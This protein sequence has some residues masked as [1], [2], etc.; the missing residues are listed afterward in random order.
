MALARWR[1]TSDNKVIAPVKGRA[2]NLALAIHRSQVYPRR[3]KPS[4][5]AARLSRD[6]REMVQQHP[7]S[8]SRARASASRGP[9]RM[10]RS[11][12]YAT[13]LERKVPERKTVPRYDLRA[14]AFS[15]TSWNGR[16]RSRNRTAIPWQTLIADSRLAARIGSFLHESRMCPRRNNYIR[17][18]TG[19]RGDSRTVSALPF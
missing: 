1:A 8:Y 11:R 10:S 14:R 13:R 19:E 4:T 16:Y 9:R 5:L 2:M 15:R 7:R 12:D 3:H 6:N 18:Q 17:R